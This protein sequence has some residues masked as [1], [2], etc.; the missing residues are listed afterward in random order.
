MTTWEELGLNW[1]A[2]GRRDA[3]VL[4]LSNALGGTAAMWDPQLAALT[5]HYRVVRYDQRGHGGSPVLPGPYLLEDLAGDVLALL[6]HLEVPSASFAGASLGGVIGL[7]LGAH[8]AERIDALTV[9]GTSAW[10]DRRDAELDRARAAREHGTNELVA[11]TIERWFTP[12]FRERHAE[13]AASYA[14]M[15]AG[16]DDEAYARCCEVLA[17]ADLRAELSSISAPTL[18]ISGAEDPATPPEHGAAI[19]D[20]IGGNARLEVV[21]HAAHLANVERAAEVNSL[22]LADRSAWSR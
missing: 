18:V 5:E 17:R 8:A 10:L 19:A 4:V 13:E 15:I 21:D 22:L 9:C 7:W 12:Y 14:A 6:D 16:A 2:D 20:G 3:P 1:L 11:P